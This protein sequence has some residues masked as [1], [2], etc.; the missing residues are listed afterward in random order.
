LSAQDAGALPSLSLYSKESAKGK[1]EVLAGWELARE[2]LV[3]G[4]G[5]GILS[6]FLG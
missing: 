1:R 6:M 4:A 5:D 3:K 2:V